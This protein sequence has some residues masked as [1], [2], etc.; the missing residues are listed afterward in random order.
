[1]QGLPLCSVALDEHACV[2]GGA[3]LLLRLLATAHAAGRSVVDA[4]RAWHRGRAVE[5]ER[6]SEHIDLSAVGAAVA[7]EWKP[8]NFSFAYELSVYARTAAL[9]TAAW[10]RRRVDGSSLPRATALTALTAHRSSPLCYS[11]VTP[12]RLFCGS[13]VAPL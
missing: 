10:R 7:N 5:R 9:P 12:L 4:L 8:L 3:F 2:G 6:A 11:S 1:M 13:S